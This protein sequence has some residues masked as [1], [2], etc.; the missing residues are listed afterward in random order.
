[1]PKINDAG[2]ALIKEFEGCRLNAYRD[3]VGVLTI[4]YGHTGQDVWT[5][6]VI[7]EAKAEA[8]LIKD[9]E[10]FENGVQDL[11]Q[12][13]AIT[14]NQ[15]SALVCFAY[16]LGLGNLEKSTLLKLVNERKFQE[17]A[18]QFLVWD[19]AGGE[20]VPGL[21]RRRQAERALFLS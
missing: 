8:L 11:L 3:I 6:Q 1:M 9:L 10:K 2:L 7:T 15:F 18:E 14:N 17:A 20:V 13:S 12:V 21:L 16:N 19:R 4:G 5:N